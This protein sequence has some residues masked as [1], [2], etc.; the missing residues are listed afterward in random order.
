VLAIGRTDFDFFADEHAGQ[1]L[2]DEQ[3]IIRTGRP[4]SPLHDRGGEIVGTFGLSRDITE[5]R[6]AR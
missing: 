5:R 6:A 2:R 3:E 4:S 1:A